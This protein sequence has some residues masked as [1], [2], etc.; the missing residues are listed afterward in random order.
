MNYFSLWEEKT[1]KIPISENIKQIYNLT[2]DTVEFSIPPT[3]QNKYI[4]LQDRIISTVIINNRWR[5]PIYF[6]S[7]DDE[8]FKLL[9]PYIRKEGLVYQVLPVKNADDDKDILRRD[10]SA[11]SYRGLDNKT[12]CLDEV[13]RDMSNQYYS[14]FLS[15]AKLESSQKNYIEAKK[16]IRFMQSALPFDRLFPDSVTIKTADSLNNYLK[17]V[18]NVNK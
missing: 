17:N 12:L 4:R 7:F 14:S 15:L 11:Y 8:V 5:R 2:S 1:E 10:L 18:N 9:G 13:T 3:I 16:I 6:T